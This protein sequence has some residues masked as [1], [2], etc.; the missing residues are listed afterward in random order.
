MK[1][2]YFFKSIPL[3]SIFL[4]LILLNLSNNNKNTKLRI[5]IWNTP[6]LS[7]NT[8]LT[9][10]TGAGFALSYLITSCL[11]NI[12][13]V[14]L[15]HSIKYKV[16]NY[17]EETIDNTNAKINSS[18]QKTLIE[19]D[20]NDSL[21]TMNASFRVVGKADIIKSNL[22]NINQFDESNEFVEDFSEQEDTYGVNN[23]TKTNISDWNDDSFLIW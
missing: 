12:N 15:K 5:L 9:I 3:I 17:N 1:S 19:R 13:P 2:Y 8:Y 21:P 16:E 11:A 4:L 7:L 14:K 22:N 10:S 18:Y 23:Q 20:I 6:S